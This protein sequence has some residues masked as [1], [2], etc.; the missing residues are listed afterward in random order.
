MVNAYLA[1]DLLEDLAVKSRKRRLGWLYASARSAP[2]LLTVSMSNE[3]NAPGTVNDAG[4]DT[5]G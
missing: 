3:E 2:I 4:K 5:C 1:S